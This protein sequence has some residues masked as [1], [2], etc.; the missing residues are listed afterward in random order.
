MP[1]DL[2]PPD[3]ARFN[4]AGFADLLPERDHLIGEDPGTFEGFRVAMMQSLA[5]LTPYECVVA[6]NLISIEWELLQRRHM[7]DVAL[8]QFICKTIKDAF[9]R[10]QKL[11]FKSEINRLWD[12]HLAAGGS[13]EDWQDPI[14]FNNDAA[15][16][17]GAALARR[18]V[19][20][21]LSVQKL[22]YAE[23]IDLGLEPVEI[24]SEAYRSHDRSITGHDQKLPELERRRR[25]VKRDFD[26]L[27]RSRPIEVEIIEG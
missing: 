4:L 3:P 26:M 5:P 25:E 11:L 21:D 13:E 9:I 14:R 8:R 23:I 19:S 22:A 1:N 27:Q 6:E 7:R 18:A 17:E 10:K 12:A 16:V 15:N 20:K 2:T 24:M